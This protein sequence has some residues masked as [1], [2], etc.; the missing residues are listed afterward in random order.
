[1]RT[2]LIA[3]SALALTT[4]ANAKVPDDFVVVHRD[5]DLS[6][7]HDQETLKNRIATEARDYCRQLPVR[8]QTGSRLRDEMYC[9][10]EATKLANQQ[11]AVLVDQAGKGG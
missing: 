5:L 3:L 4:T 9:V 7:K 6:N 10:S 1:M 8:T 2:M 11:M